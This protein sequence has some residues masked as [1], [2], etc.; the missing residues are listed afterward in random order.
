MSKAKTNREFVKTLANLCKGNDLPE[1][2]ATVRQA[3]KYRN[4]KGRCYHN[5]K[6]MY[7]GSH[8]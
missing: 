5:I 1:E 2:W 7:G 8:G 3:S 6:R 4:G